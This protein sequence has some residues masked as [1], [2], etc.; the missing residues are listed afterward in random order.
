MPTFKHPCPYCGKLIDRVVAACPFCGVIEPFSPKRCQN[1]SRII[2]DPAWVACP[3]CGLSLL[4][5]PPVA[6]GAAGATP[7]QAAPGTPPPQAATPPPP[8]APAPQPLPVAP[9]PQSAGPCSGCGAPL[10]AGARF[11]AICGTVAG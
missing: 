4:A 1:C 6:A 3:S 11:C 8:P 2:E 7:A 5:P 9:A 10:P